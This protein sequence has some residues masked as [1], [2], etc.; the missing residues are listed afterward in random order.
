MEAG[1]ADLV[2]SYR[3]SNAD[4]SALALAM[5]LDP[6]LSKLALRVGLLLCFRYLN[7]RTGVARPGGEAMAADLQADRSHLRK[8]VKELEAGGFWAVQRD[9]TPGRSRV[10]F[11]APLIGERGALLSPFPIVAKMRKGGKNGP[12]RGAP[13]SPEPIEP[14]G[15]ATGGEKSW[16]VWVATSETQPRFRR[17]AARSPK[18]A[19][20][21]P[22]TTG[23]S[24]QSTI[25][26]RGSTAPLGGCAEPPRSTFREPW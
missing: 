9:P 1:G 15:S 8:A 21:N 22:A 12:K 5:S 24:D 11:Y 6:D 2:T 4:R 3:I 13:L 16:S 18:S 26:E 14:D 7:R 17:G 19:E 20:P 25:E 10:N 23:K